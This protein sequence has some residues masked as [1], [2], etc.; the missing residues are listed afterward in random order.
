MAAH[1]LHIHGIHVCGVCANF[2]SCTPLPIS[3]AALGDCHNFHRVHY[4]RCVVTASPWLV[5]GIHA[6]LSYV[7]P[8]P[9]TPRYLTTDRYTR[10]RYE[11][12]YPQYDELPRQGREKRIS[13]YPSRKLRAGGGGGGGVCVGGG[14]CVGC[15]GWVAFARCSAIGLFPDAWLLLHIRLRTRR[16]KRWNSMGNSSC[17]CSRASNTVASESQNY[18]SNWRHKSEFETHFAP[19]NLSVLEG[20]G[21]GWGVCIGAGVPTKTRLESSIKFV[22]PHLIYLL[23]S[24]ACA[25]RWGSLACRTRY[26][27]QS[28]P[29]LK[30]TRIF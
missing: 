12:P 25:R 13:T 8:H 11:A 30:R 22:N 10:R 21:W 16:R 6:E 27:Q 17:A 28:P 24:Q 3:P 7:C 26:P 4:L 29:R 20:V 15:V 5:E 19:S 9:Q 14:G 23:I 18:N 1:K 2:S